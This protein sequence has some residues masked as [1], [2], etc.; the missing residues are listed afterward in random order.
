MTKD[1]LIPE[2]GGI[3]GA[4]HLIEQ[5]TEEEDCKVLTY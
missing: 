5:V 2:R 1:D 4:A 3:I